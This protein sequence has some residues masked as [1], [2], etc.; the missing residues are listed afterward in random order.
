[1]AESQTASVTDTVEP[2]PTKRKFEEVSKSTSISDGAFGVGEWKPMYI[3]GTHNCIIEKKK[4]F[5]FAIPH[6]T[7][8]LP[9][10]YSCKLA[11]NARS[12]SITV[13]WPQ[14]LC[15]NED[16]IVGSFFKYQKYFEKN[17]FKLK[18]DLPWEY[19]APLSDS[20]GRF[21]DL[22]FQN[23]GEEDQNQLVSTAKF[24][25]DDD[26]VLERK[27]LKTHIVAGK[28]AAGES[29]GN[30]ITFRFLI[31]VPQEDTESVHSSPEKSF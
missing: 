23:T 3:C 18:K 6:I 27:R 9:A 30:V 26:I 24:V 29:I 19:S 20:K 12:L 11:E 17:V 13:K 28:N 10:D 2:S 14:F 21:N 15:N 4:V 16:I 25:L 22:K 31:Y 8:T 1:M 5:S 7:G